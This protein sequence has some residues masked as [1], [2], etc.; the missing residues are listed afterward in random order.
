MQRQLIA[1]SACTALLLTSALGGEQMK[2]T[3]HPH[4]GMWVTK[5]GDIRHQ[6]LANGR[7]DEARGSR[8]SAYQ[9][10]YEII[11]NHIEY[12]DDSGFTADGD[13]IDGVLYHGGMVF[14]RK[15]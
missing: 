2:Q 7:Y 9:G 6:L 11:G 1:V 13:F 15:F 4:V 12:W 5:D 3:N 14:Y 8:E 10:H